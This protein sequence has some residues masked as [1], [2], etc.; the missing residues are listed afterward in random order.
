[1]PRRRYVQLVVLALLLT[2]IVLPSR[3]HAADERCFPETKLCI[4]GEFR[5]YWERN[6]G[7]PVFGLPIT[8]ARSELNRD[9]GRSYLTQWFERSRLELHPTDDGGTTVLLGR[10]GDDALLQHGVNWRQL[11]PEQPRSDCLWFNETQ[12][13][14]CDQVPGEGFKTYWQ[15]H[16]LELGDAGTNTRESLSLFGLPLTEP[17]RETNASGDEV[18]TQWFERARFEYHPTKPQP[19]RVLLGLLGSEVRSDAGS[20]TPSTP[21]VEQISL[22]L[23]EWARGL[24][25]PVLVT[26]AG[27]GSGRLFAVEKG[28]VIRLLPG[29][30]VF[31][32]IN[33]RVGAKGMEQGLLGLAFHPRFRENGFFFVNYTDFRGDTVIARYKT[34]ADGRTADLDTEQRILVQPQ[35]DTNHNGGMLAF[36]PD[37]YLYIGLG[38]GGGANDAYRNAQNR[39]TLLGKILRIDVNRGS[40]YAIPR[41]NPFVNDPNTKPEIWALGL[42]NPWRFSFDRATGDLFIGDVGQN[43]YEWVHYQPRTS[44]GGQNYGWPIVEGS[45]CLINKACD[46]TGITMPIAEYDHRLGCAITG[47]YVYRGA[48]YPLLRGVYVFGDFCSG[49][50][51]TLTGDNVNGWQMNEKLKTDVL[52]SSFGEDEAGEL[53]V[54]DLQAGRVYR[55][56]AEQP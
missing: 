51:W 4:S 52:I 17:R 6:G 54:T 3:T 45:H 25:R 31:L 38:D 40:P 26:N 16:G 11:P 13:N 48:R 47:G 2:I 32:D 34:R 29:G 55:V 15:T 5:R 20:T 39:S 7:L 9:L 36:G 53:Y 56:L 42:R 21:E 27:D 35:P 19:Y 28:G 12:H 10:L 46:R 43:R 23:Q 8:P 30:E 24:D 49:R 44:G 1:M 22:K 14:L 33:W 18:L 41:D 50:I 37:G